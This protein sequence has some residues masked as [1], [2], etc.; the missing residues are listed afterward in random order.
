MTSFTLHYPKS[1]PYGP[2]LAYITVTRYLWHI[3]VTILLEKLWIYV[4]LVARLRGLFSLYVTVI[5]TAASPSIAARQQPSS[6][7]TGRTAVVSHCARLLWFVYT[8]NV[9]WSF[10]L[11][12]PTPVS[13]AAAARR[14][15]TWSK[16]TT[17]RPVPRLGR[18][19]N[20]RIIMKWNNIWEIG[21]LHF[22][23]R[24]GDGPSTEVGDWM[25][26]WAVGWFVAWLEGWVVE[27]GCM[28]DY[29][30]VSM[31]FTA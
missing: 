4:F 10:P 21:N 31:F 12:R 23:C 19:L 30:S 5:V 17:E 11:S 18:L 8:R 7:R 20:T 14:T 27:Q 25:G 26:G 22:K 1:L 2:C 13:H 16:N 3:P 28:P 9:G 15:T 29:N 6:A 24:L